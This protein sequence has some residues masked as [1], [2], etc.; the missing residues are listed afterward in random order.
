MDFIYDLDFYNDT[1]YFNHMFYESHKRIIEL[2]ANELDN[3]DKTDYLVEKFLGKPIKFKKRKDPNLPKRAKSSYLF[4]CEEKR[5]E[6]LK[7]IPGKSVVI[8][9]KH[10]G[11]LWGKLNEEEKDKYQELYIKDKERYLEEMEEYL[12]NKKDM[13][14]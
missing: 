7:Q 14:Y 5:P 3:C 9:S 6:V 13:S 4:F 1:V 10:L 12:Q 11:S 2:V 8:Q